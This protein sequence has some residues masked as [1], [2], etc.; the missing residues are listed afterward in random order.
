MGSM[1]GGEVVMRLYEAA[2]VFRPEM[3]EAALEQAIDR[4]T[5]VARDQG[6]EPGTPDRWGKRR[7]AYEIDRVN[8]GLYVFLPFRA[9]GTAVA[10]VERHLR[11]SDDVLR[12]LVVAPPVEPAQPTEPASQP[13][14]AVTEAEKA[15]PTEEAELAP[16]PVTAEAEPASA[17]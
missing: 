1:G 11:L 5:R 2:I 16:Q 4:V 12:Y 6:G 14:P 9:P 10:E 15:E 17:S 8:E 3:D 7:L 13:T